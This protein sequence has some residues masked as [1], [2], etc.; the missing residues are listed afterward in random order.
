MSALAVTV[1]V[2]SL[3][4]PDAIDLLGTEG[5]GPHLIADE[6]LHPIFSFAQ[7]YFYES[8]CLQAPTVAVLRE[9]FGDLLDDHEIDLEV[10]PE[11]TPEWAIRSLKSTKVHL[12]SNA[13]V[14]RMATEMASAEVDDRVE[15]LQRHA[16]DLVSLA[17]SMDRRSARVDART[18]GADLLRSYQARADER[19]TFRGMGIGVGEVD[20]FMGGI[21]ES[22]LGILAGPTKSG[23]S[24]MAAWT[25]L[26]EWRRGRSTVLYTLENTVEMTMDRIACMATNVDAG[27]WDRGEANAEEVD[28][29]IAWL[30]ELSESPTPLWIVQ[31]ELGQRSFPAMVQNARLLDAQS[32]I[33]DQLTFV[34]MGEDDRRSK[35]QQIGDALHKL[36]AMIGGR[37]P[38][39]CLLIHQVSRDGAKYADKAGYLQSWHVADSAEVER[40]AD[41]LLGLYRSPDEKVVGEAKLQLMAARRTD[42]R[43]W[44][45]KFRPYIG[46]VDAIR[47]ITL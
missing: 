14:K 38:L 3:T 17:V 28:E 46:V 19:N 13:F 8:G 2:Q 24:L 23:K 21:R 20:G 43:A 5:F 1:L 44:Q 27:L 6:S 42:T 36:K 18:A 12:E 40:T 9:N 29:V 11:G 22:E 35:T 45:M 7:R 16:A 41:F 4:D 37:F 32:M 31:P 34:E 25:A 47:P 39:S 33:V 10:D 26:S 30:K 15:V